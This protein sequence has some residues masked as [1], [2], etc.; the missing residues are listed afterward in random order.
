MRL[1]CILAVL[2]VLLP[3]RAFAAEEG[4]APDGPPPLIMEEFAYQRALFLFNTGQYLAA[5]DLAATLLNTPL[6]DRA[7]LL[8]MVADNR[9]LNRR[10]YPPFTP[11]APMLASSDVTLLLDDVY[12]LMD[13]EQTLDV[14]RML[15][16]KGASRYFEGLSLLKLN[17][18]GEASNALLKVSYDDPFYP[19]ARIALAQTEV[20]RQDL[21]AAIQYLNGLLEHPGVRGKPLAER[22]HLLIGQILFE[23]KLYVEALSEFLMVRP[24][25]RFYRAAINGM[26]WSLVKLERC[27]EAVTLA[28]GMSLGPSFDLAG[29]D[30]KVMLGYCYRDSGQTA[31]ALE[32]YQALLDET[33]ESIKRVSRVIEDEGARKNYVAALTGTD[34]SQMEGVDANDL[35]VLWSDPV[36]R[37]FLIERRSIEIIRGSL[38][39]KERE[40][41]GKENYLTNTGR[42]IKTLI[43]SIEDDIEM[44]RGLFMV[45][46]RKAEQK[47]KTRSALAYNLTFFNSTEDYIYKYWRSVLKRDVSAGARRTVRLILQEWVEKESMVCPEKSVMCYFVTFLGMDEIKVDPAQVREIVKA[48]EMLGA[49]LSSVEEGEKLEVEKR[50]AVLREKALERMERAGQELER[51]KRMRERV[52]RDE[53]QIDS[54]S[55][56]QL[57]LMDKYIRE[58]FVK[59]RYDLANTR[60]EI[61]AEMESARKN[62]SPA[63]KRE[64]GR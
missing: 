23:R 36:I 7:N 12:R 25:S 2:I 38:K 14:S 24:E 37:G 16:G 18:F 34:N 30:S 5:A 53:E 27:D 44:M 26:A 1:I 61:M 57:A 20:R 52:R 45:M 22:V 8:L 33:R 40:I 17:S 60:D 54:L 46:K 32:N 35:S 41:A 4:V 21:K 51:L 9:T 43:R 55:R 13:Y 3:V 58:S 59:T 29:S 19:F 28:K 48:L 56:K 49:D 11:G 50:F 10:V 15:S 62:A 31:L 39:E 64:E 47:E 63:G 42:G 6:N